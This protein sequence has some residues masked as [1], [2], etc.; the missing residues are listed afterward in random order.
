MPSEIFYSQLAL[1]WCLWGIGRDALVTENCFCVEEVPENHFSARK[2]NPIYT[3][4]WWF[5]RLS[6][7]QRWEQPWGRLLWCPPILQVAC[8]AGLR[9]F[10]VLRRFVICR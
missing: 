10:V 5:P 3:C 2:L 6:D 4:C 7:W 1:N 8:Q 9:S